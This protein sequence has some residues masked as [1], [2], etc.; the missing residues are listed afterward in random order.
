MKNELRVAIP[1]AIMH[2][3]ERVSSAE[4]ARAEGLTIAREML[5]AVKDT[6]QGVQ[7]S[8]PFGRYVYAVEVLEGLQSTDAPSA[9]VN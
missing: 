5:V 3:M 9:Q 7:I 1:D 8:A 2:R 6:L 4:A